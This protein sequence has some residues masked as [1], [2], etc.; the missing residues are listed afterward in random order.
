MTDISQLAALREV[1]ERYVNTVAPPASTF[2][3][4]RRLAREEL[5]IEI[6]AVAI[7]PE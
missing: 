5:M 2:V 1:R 4:V 7:L 6:E 3:E